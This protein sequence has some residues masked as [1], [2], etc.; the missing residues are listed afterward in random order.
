MVKN[1]KSNPG[2][3]VTSSEQFQKLQEK[4]DQLQIDFDAEKK[5]YNMLEV[6]HD[7]FKEKMHAQEEKYKDH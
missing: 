2:G 5:H 1:I 7:T 3:D 4:F 6:K